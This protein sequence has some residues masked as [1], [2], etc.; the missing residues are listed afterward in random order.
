MT[1]TASTFRV[2]TVFRADTR[3]LYIPA[4]LI[5]TTTYGVRILSPLFFRQKRLQR[6][7]SSRLPRHR[8][9]S[10]DLNTGSVSGANGMNHYTEPPL[11]KRLGVT[12]CR[13][14]QR[15]HSLNVG[16]NPLFWSLFFEW[17]PVPLPNLWITELPKKEFNKPKP[18]PLSI[19]FSLVRPKFELAIES[20]THAEVTNNKNSQLFHLC[21]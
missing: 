13:E 12:I 11:R 9:W 10:R 3:R 4:H 5:F 2:P 20:A 21:C 19:L 8:W 17:A 16:S 15:H 7:K 6:T 1:T 18:P 14:E